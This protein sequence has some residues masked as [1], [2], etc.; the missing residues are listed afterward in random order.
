MLVSK[1]KEVS[2][3][4]LLLLMTVLILVPID[5]D[6]ALR[7]ANAEEWYFKASYED[8]SPSGVPDF[9][10][11][12]DNWNNSAGVWTWCGPLA[13]ANSLWWFDSKFEPNPVPPPALNDGFP[14]LSSLVGS[15]DDHHPDNVQPFVDDLAWF[16]DTD[17]QRTGLGHNGT[18][19]HDMETG[20]AR[21]LSSVHPLPSVGLNPRGDAN[22]DGRV[23]ANDE[24]IVLNAMGSVPGAPNWNLAA[25]LN[26]DNMVDPQDLDLVLLHLGEAW[27]RFYEKTVKMPTFEYIA[28]QVEKSEDVI[29]LLGF[30]Q[31]QGA[32]WVRLGGHYVTVAGVN[33]TGLSLAFSD[34][35]RDDAELGYPGQVIPPPPHP[36]NSS[37][38]FPL[39][40]NASYVSHDFYGFASLPPS[41]GGNWGPKDYN[42]SIPSIENFF[43]QNIPDDFE[44]E[45]FKGAYIPSLSVYVYVEYSVIVSPTPDAAV[46][47]VAPR[48]TV[49]P[50]GYQMPL[51]VTVANQGLS[52]G[53]FN[54]TAYYHATEGFEGGT[55]AG[56]D[57]DYSTNGAQSGSNAAGTW[58][59][60]IVSGANALSGSYSARLLA[61]S[62]ASYPPWQVDAAINRTINRGSGSVLHANLKFSDIQGSGGTGL[63]VFGIKVFNGLDPTKW[64]YYGFCTTGDYGDISYTV[65]PGDLVNF[66]RDIVVDYFNKYNGDLPDEI[67]VCFVSSAD[68]A[69]GIPEA[70]TTD[71]LVDD[72]CIVDPDAPIGTNTVVLASGASAVITFTWDTTGLGKGNYVVSAVADIIVG[73]ADTAD[74]TKINGMAFVTIAGDINADGGVDSSDLADVSDAYGSLPSLPGW[75][76][77]CDINNDDQIDIS[78]LHELAQNFGE[79]SL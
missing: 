71:V 40:N 79:D 33:S 32:S 54:V 35:I 12:Q 50:R 39:H 75:N 44:A 52:A 31:P 21:Y 27:G 51:N 1:R 58:S 61:D 56:W 74:N 24:T 47:S 2:L 13:V 49:V 65:S 16:M 20:I 78:D 66:Q 68:Y 4:I 63:S 57:F 67:I 76:P 30:W 42:R 9:D 48:N 26:G 59:S 15:I 25:D 64:V 62:D 14:L 43:G 8:Y 29:I 5:R 55:F 36:H 19:V 3:P 70:R 53:T 10:Q 72:F 7:G 69:E 17:G 18:R 34:P 38:P 37:P 41:P 22:G 73:E 77:N 45:E 23:D 6:L 46:T 60:S 11:R 28:E